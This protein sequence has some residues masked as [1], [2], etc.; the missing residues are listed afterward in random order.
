MFTRV[1]P[2]ERPKHV[3]VF[4]A[5]PPSF[6]GKG[7]AELP[8]VQSRNPARD[9]RG[10]LRDVSTGRYEGNGHAQPEPYGHPSSRI[11]WRMQ[12]Q[13]GYHDYELRYRFYEVSRSEL[14][15]H[16]TCKCMHAPRAT[17]RELLP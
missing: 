5:R 7:R 4:V 13:A 8:L 11:R 12:R 15:R 2:H 9:V 6:A 16:Q 10:L 14:C 1:R 3:L 17:E